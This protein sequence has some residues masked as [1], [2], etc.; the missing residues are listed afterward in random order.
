MPGARDAVKM[1]GRAF[2]RERDREASQRLAGLAPAS[3]FG[4]DFGA[5]FGA[6]RR[7]APQSRRCRPWP[8]GAGPARVPITMDSEAAPGRSSRRPGPA[9]PTLMPV[10]GGAPSRPGQSGG[11]TGSGPRLPPAA[12]K[13]HSPG[14]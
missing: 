6:R 11:V 4:A 8:S 10:L 1:Q 13:T 5:D 14:E 9:R 12:G 7:A 3:E 2:R